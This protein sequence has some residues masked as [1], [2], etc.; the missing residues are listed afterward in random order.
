[1]GDEW[2]CNKTGEVAIK[3]TVDNVTLS[4]RRWIPKGL[5]V[6]FTKLGGLGGPQQNAESRNESEPGS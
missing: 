5:G 1:M 2:L 6:N 4:G 3:A